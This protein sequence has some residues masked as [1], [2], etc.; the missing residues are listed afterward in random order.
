MPIIAEMSHRSVCLGEP[1]VPTDVKVGDGALGADELKFTW[2]APVHSCDADFPVIRY[3]LLC[4]G[5]GG[6]TPVDVIVSAPS[7]ERVVSESSF[8][9]SIHYNCSVSA[10]NTIGHS[11]WSNPFLLRG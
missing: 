1:D 5:G 2:M 11:S 6:S 3:R 10:E 8:R 7:S 9:S 4:R